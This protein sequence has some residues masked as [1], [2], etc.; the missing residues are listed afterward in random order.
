MADRGSMNTPGI[1]LDIQQ[2]QLEAQH[3]WL[4]PA[5]ICEILRN[6]QKFQISSEPPT[7]PSSG[8]LFLFDRKVL[9][10]F[11]KDGHNWRKKKDGKT[12]KEAHEKLKV[13]SVDVLHCYYAHGEDNDCFQR[14]SYWLLEEEFMHI[15]FVHYLEVKGNRSSMRDTEPVVS[16]PQFS[17]SVSSSISNSYNEAFT[18]NAGSPSAVSSLTSSYED[19]ESEDNHQAMSKYPSPLNFPLVDDS[20]ENNKLGSLMNSNFL[21]TYPDD[22]KGGRLS[23][24]GLDYVSLVQ[25]GAGTNDYNQLRTLDLGSWEEVFQQC[26]NDSGNLPHNPLIS[27]APLVGS[28]NGF[29]ESF[30]QLLDSGFGVNSASAGSLAP[31]LQNNNPLEFSSTEFQDNTNISTTAKQPLLGNIRAE[32]GLQKVDSFNK[33]MTKELA[34]VDDLDLKSSS[35]LSWQNI[36]SASAVDDPSIQ[37]ENYSMSP[38]IGQDQLFDIQDFSPSCASTDSETKVVITGKFLVSPSDV[39]K[40]KWS[41]MFGEV[42]VPAEVLGNGVLCCYAPLHSVGQVPFYVTCSNRFACSQ[43]R[44]FEYLVEGQKANII[45]GSGNSMTEKQLWL[46]LQKL[47]SLSSHGNFDSTSENIRKKEPIFRKIFLLMEDELCLGVEL[48]LKEKVVSWL[49]DKV[50]D[51]GKGPNMLDEEGQGLLHLAA[52]LA[53]DWIIPPTLAAG[54][55]VNFRD[56]NGW[57]ALHWAAFYGREKTVAFLVALEAASGALTDPSPE[58]PLG[59]TAADL[60]SANGY[61]GISGFLAEHS[62][63]AHLETLTMTDRKKDSPVESSMSKAVQTMREKVVT[64]G[65]EGDGS[66]LSLKDSLAAV[67]NATQAAGRIHQV[68]RMQSFQRKQVSKGVGGDESLLSDEQFLSLVSSKIKRP[69]RPDEQS[70]SAATHI[71]KKFRGWKKRKE[72]LIIRERVVRIQAHVRGHQVRKR[73]KPVV[74]SVGILEKA[75]LRWRRKGQG[76]RGFRSD[77]LNK[78]SSTQGTQVVQKKPSEED[79]YD[80]LKEGR[81]QTEERLQ[82]ALVRVK[83]MVQY[84]EGRAQYR[85]L[86]TAVEGFQKNQPYDNSTLNSSENVPAEGEDD[87]IDVD[88]LLDDDNFMAIA[89]E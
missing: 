19:I 78:A 6:F 77:A 39:C 62:L 66:D 46:R 28:T 43:V 80:Y 87:M 86:L 15:V 65:D 24:P 84:P 81:K 10:Y 68:F 17:N 12:V 89:F 67:R 74:W 13:G 71:Q 26:T 73:Y 38:S 2:L 47:L 22:Y 42:E 11:R 83:S 60:A 4:R 48:H 21:P 25:R 35:N 31:F 64:P 55:S 88:S 37:L 8:S 20:F 50:S 52:A 82:K 75:I 57:T 49:F 33:W 76:L 16:S 51:D 40:Y 1:R 72:F 29:N 30:T 7:R 54:V 59:R 9:R 56:I 27:G 5:E 18:G 58:F 45:N 61:K 69:G 44:E 23:G 53:F 32:E 41:C 14:R 70:H 3:R 85:R 63:T 36:E 79:D 34:G